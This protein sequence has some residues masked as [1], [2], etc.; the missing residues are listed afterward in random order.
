M[1][2]F[3]F[4]P[5]TYLAT[6]H[7]PTAFSPSHEEGTVLTIAS[8]AKVTVIGEDPDLDELV[9]YWRNDDGL[10]ETAILQYIEGTDGDGNP[11]EEWISSLELVAD[12]ALDGQLL[13]V[14]VRDRNPQAKM[15]TL[16]WTLEVP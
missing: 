11:Y 14:Q 1:G 12:P 8:R 4:D 2:C 9:F 16:S 3:N 15:V 13:E 7:A 10:L 6:N 5:P